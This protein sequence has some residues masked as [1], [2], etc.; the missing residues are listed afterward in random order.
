MLRIFYDGQFRSIYQK[1][2][3]LEYSNGSLIRKTRGTAY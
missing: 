2:A 3:K 1:T